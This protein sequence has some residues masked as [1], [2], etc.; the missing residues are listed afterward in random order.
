MDLY[1]DL[2]A[3]LNTPERLQ[4]K[5]MRR[6]ARQE[7][8]YDHIGEA[9]GETRAFQAAVHWSLHS[10]DAANAAGMPMGHQHPGVAA[11]HAVAKAL[12]EFDIPT[13][14]HIRFAGM[15]RF[16]GRG[17][18]RMDTG[19]VTMELA[20]Q[21]LSGHKDFLD[22]PVIVKE[23]RVFEPVCLIYNQNLRAMTQHTF[24]DIFKRGEFTAKVPDRKNMYSRPP[25][26]AHGE[27]H[28]V[29]LVRPGMFGFAPSNRQ[30]RAH[31]YDA[32]FD[33]EA[34]PKEWLA[35]AMAAGTMG[36]AQPSFAG[37]PAQGAPMTPP[38]Q[39]Q[40]ADP[41]AED[42]SRMPP[43]VQQQF[44]HLRKTIQGVNQ[45][46]QTMQPGTD[47]HA[48]WSERLQELMTQFD[49]YVSA[50]QQS[51]IQQQTPEQ[52][53]GP[54]KWTWPDSER[55]FTTARKVA[56]LRSAVSGHYVEALRD[57]DDAPDHT[58][59]GERPLVP[60]APGDEAK[61]NRALDVPGRSGYQWHL[62][63]GTKVNIVRDR[64]G[65]GDEFVVWA[66]GCD[67]QLI[68]PGDAIG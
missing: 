19:V 49:S 42:L 6:Q 23:G 15:K 25:G 22:I 41:M 31:R 36:L 45:Q 43:E 34:G 10:H 1:G 20:L 7:A 56:Y 47:Q 29:P 57:F 44:N 35:G 14:Y 11:H 33:R 2:H 8:I 63:K 62:E 50:M 38:A 52:M 21:S 51:P 61:L 16:K 66:D 3:I 67:R 68:V 12:G 58:D 5:A 28:R 54:H 60:L 37:E 30:L 55:S 17:A 65:S 48:Q 18:H 13:T 27:S 64:D 9:I 4:A 53:Y 26:E 32:E 59:V 40:A 24:D 39:E 46:L